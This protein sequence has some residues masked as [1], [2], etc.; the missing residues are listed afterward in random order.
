MF[1]STIHVICYYN[2]NILRTETYVKYVGN[3]AVIVPLDVPVECTFE[4]L[5]DMIYSRTTIDKQIFKLVLNCKYPYK[6][7]ISSNLFQYGMR[8][9]YQMLNMVNRTSIEEIEL[10]IEVVRVKPQVN[11]SMSGH[12]DLLV[13]DNYNVAEFDSGRGPSSG[14]ILD[15]GVYG[16]DEDY[17]YEE[18]NDE[19]VDDEFNGDADV[20]DNG[21]VS[22]FQIFNQVLENDQGIYVSTHAASCDVSNNPDVEEPDESSPVHYHLPPTPQFEHVE[23]LCNAI[24]SGW[25]P[26]VQHTIDYLSREFVVGQ[27]FNSKFDF[28]EAAKIYSIKAHQD[29]AIVASSK[30]LLVL[31]YKKAEECQCLW[32]LHVIVVKDT[33]LFVINKY[34]GP[35][36]FVNPFLN[37]DHH[38]LDSNLVTAHIKA[39]IKAQFTLTTISIQASVM[40]KWGYEISYKKAEDG[41]HKALRQLFG[42]F[43]QSY[44]ELPRLFLAIEQANPGRVVIWKIFDT[45]MLNTQIFQCVF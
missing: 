22:S 28:Q 40:E 11:Q 42:D 24:S 33:C 2:G 41:K 9:V 32:K 12:I 6:V 5:S 31:R 7:E 21:H 30:K 8:V 3:K 25:T 23:N 20:Q 38:Q 45:N 35:H 19:D 36:T 18:A 16:D 34:K 27:V 39:I 13:L 1:V 14:P 10:Y 15:T 26:W 37:Q 29:F 43:S 17:A 44:T 4:Q